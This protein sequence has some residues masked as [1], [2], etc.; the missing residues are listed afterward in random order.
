[1]FY[2][3]RGFGFKRFEKN[4]L[5]PFTN[6]IL[7]YDKI[8]VTEFI[9]SDREEFIV[10]LAI[11]NK[12]EDKFIKSYKIGDFKIYQHDSTIYINSL[13][14]FFITNSTEEV[15]KLKAITGRSLEVKNVENYL[16][17]VKSLD[18]YN[19][20]IS[21]LNF[22]VTNKLIDFKTYNSNQIIF[23]R[24]VNKTKGF[25]YGFL[26]GKLSE[27]PEEITISKQYYQ[28]FI[29]IF[30]LLINELSTQ[31][32]KENKWSKKPSDLTGYYS[33]LNEI[34]ERIDILL[35][36]YDGSKIETK[37]VEEFNI[38]TLSLKNLKNYF[39]KGY[40]K[41]LFQIIEDYVRS[42][43]LNSLS[44]EELLKHLIGKSISF[45]KYPSI[46][47]YNALEGDFNSIRNI[48][49]QKFKEREKSNSK[50]EGFNLL[51]FKYKSENQNISLISDELAK[52]ELTLYNIVIQEL[53]SHEELSSS[54][55]I[56][57][58]R[59]NILANIGKTISDDKI[60]GTES[61]EL[62]YLRKLYES[63][64]TIGVGFK[65]NEI[66]NITLQSL[67]SFLNRYSDYEKLSDFLIKNNVS[68]NSLVMGIWGATYGY[69]NLSKIVLSSLFSNNEILNKTIKFSNIIS[70]SEVIDDVSLMELD[71]NLMKKENKIVKSNSTNSIK[72]AD[73]NIDDNDMFIDMILANVKLKGATDEWIELIK[74]S[75]IEVNN[76]IKS[77]ELF[78]AFDSKVSLFKDKL[79]KYSKRTKGFGNV[80]IDET[81]NTFIKY[82]KK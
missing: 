45:T 52:T 34:V 80:K 20:N 31:V 82:L 57:Q 78:D 11:P 36:A 10:Y 54:D 44:I 27:Q 62:K 59:L 51:P 69:S 37:I 58:I 71:K 26:S 15:L 19:F 1:V 21:K 3:K 30:S 6:S 12:G 72:I 74:Q 23:D 61:D 48:I 49:S 32:S 65:I 55:E 46:N 76:E 33:K 81:T 73:S 14:C 43:N 53:L 75:F 38:D 68:S 66:D 47:N 25:V 60:F 67:A 7:L 22:E 18:I 64:K 41:S 28:E 2:E 13:E 35:G 70:N 63:L 24:K 17:S 9:K 8:P 50:Q 29:N 42:K 56:G 16:N 4:L 77:G 40:K 79:V 5:N 39:S